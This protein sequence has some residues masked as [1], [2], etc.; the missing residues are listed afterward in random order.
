MISAADKV[1][2]AVTI[3]VADSGNADAEIVQRFADDAAA[4]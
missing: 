3:L 4:V 1:G 2:I